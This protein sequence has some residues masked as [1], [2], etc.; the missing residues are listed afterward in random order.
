MKTNV[1]ATSI[2]VY[3]SEIK[4]RKEDSQNEIVFKALKKLGVGS[5]MRDIQQATKEFNNGKELEINVVSRSLNNLRVKH[6]RIDF[7][8][9]YT[10]GN[11]PR[12]L[13]HY[14][15]IQLNGQTNL[16]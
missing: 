1:S 2:E 16:F 9:A 5:I 12:Y 3:N 10:K 7:F 11:K 13:H 6:K 15:I 14:F 4:G 8:D